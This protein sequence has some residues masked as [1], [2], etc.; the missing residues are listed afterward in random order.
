MGLSNNKSVDTKRTSNS[1]GNITTGSAV[2]YA[3]MPEILPRLRRL[4]MNFGHF[5]YVMALIYSSCRLIPADHPMLN[6]ANIGRYG[7]RQVV[8]TAANNLNLSR[9]NIDQIAI[10][11][12]IL[13]GLVMTV[14][15]LI[16]IVLMVGI[17]SAKASP[18]FFETADPNTDTALTFLQSVFGVANF[19]NNTS[20]PGLSLANSFH[21]M[22]AFYS[23]A[24][25]VIAVIIVLYYVV[26]V[27]GESAQS[28]TPFGRRFNGLY[29]PLRLVLALGLL[30]PLP[31]GL[32]SGQYLV[33]HVAKFGSG[34]AT[35]AWYKFTD[36]L[37]NPSNITYSNATSAS[38][39][40][41]VVNVA[42]SV[43]MSEVCMAAYNTLQTGDAKMQLREFNHHATSY[44]GTRGGGRTVIVPGS[45]KATMAWTRDTRSGISSVADRDEN[46]GEITFKY[47]FGEQDELN[48]DLSVKAVDIYMKAIKKYAE[49]IRANHAPQ[50]VAAYKSGGTGAVTSITPQAIA[51]KMVALQAE[52]IDGFK[53]LDLK[54]LMIKTLG[55]SD[56]L[57]KSGWGEAA[58][59]Y[60]RLAAANQKIYQSI[61]ASA[62]QITSRRVVNEDT[63][64]DWYSWSWVP[65]GAGRTALDDQIAVIMQKTRTEFMERANPIMTGSDDRIYFTKQVNQAENDSWFYWAVSSIFP[66][67]DLQEVSNPATK[68]IL[69]MIKMVQ[70]GTSLVNNS[71]EMFKYAIVSSV[72]S[73]F[74]K[75]GGI[76]QAAGNILTII[77]SIGLGIG[78]MLA[79]LLPLMP[80]I[81]FFF[82]LVE[83]IMG[84]V[85]AVIN[86]PLWALSH[87]RIEGDGLP[88][89]GAQ[90]GYFI[91]F[92]ILLKPVLIVFGLVFGFMIFNAGGYILNGMFSKA[93]EIANAGAALGTFATLAYMIIYTI[94]C[95]NLGMVSFK[96]IDTIPAQAFRWM[97]QGNPHFNDGKPDP[98]GDQSRMAGAAAVAVNSL[99]QS[100]N[101]GIAATSQVAAKSVGNLIK[102][103]SNPN[104]PPGNNGGP[105]ASSTP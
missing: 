102:S 97:G 57:K 53:A 104:T 3:F 58:V 39:A 31:T 81:Y 76:M 35:N 91:L 37:F 46:C 89:P 93:V 50:M 5:A 82:A 52:V 26:V 100:T 28:G 6:P 63:N 101:S 55:N 98:I 77:A 85:E 15:Q 7:M 22:L 17:G 62:P 48:R 4:G 14:A 24:M 94:I 20:M 69:P 66:V 19:F 68:E 44:A 36:G 105:A 12:A 38:L 34:L 88:G 59:W 84:V 25:M 96:M 40:T 49:D 80:F 43:Y 86:M 78:F 41:D 95:Y 51:D 18:G 2:R 45:E 74:P 61:V 71:I 8:A 54:D 23:T 11:V 103:K 42:K 79:Y 29:A 70:L 73:M 72:A 16:I 21:Q 83:W 9:N 27:V 64:A 92:G 30:V 13:L 87:L 65:F 75:I 60:M 90:Q 32:N 33:M 67:K 10:F 1:F 56:D 47:N 99:A